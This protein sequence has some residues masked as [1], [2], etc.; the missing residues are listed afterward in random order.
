MLETPFDAETEREE[1]KS[2]FPFAISRNETNTGSS[3][4]SD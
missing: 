1:N 4:P 2:I 3:S